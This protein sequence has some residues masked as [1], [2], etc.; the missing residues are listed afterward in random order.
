[1]ND[2]AKKYSYE[3][4]AYDLIISNPPFFINQLKA[5]NTKTN[6]ALHGTSLIPLDLISICQKALHKNGSFYILLPEKEMLTFEQAAK[7][8]GLSAFDRLEIYNTPQ[9]PIFRVIQ[10]FSYIPKTKSNNMIYIKENNEY[11]PNFTRLLKNYYLH[12]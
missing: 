5:N 1:M 9:K 4:E 11:S 12:F 7:E 2:D 8:I 3:S 10:G 6:E